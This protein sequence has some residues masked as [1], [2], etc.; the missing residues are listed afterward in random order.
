[1]RLPKFD[2]VEPASIEEA[3]SILLDDPKAKILAGGT[4]LLVNMN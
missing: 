2:Y 4:D 1:M 3:S